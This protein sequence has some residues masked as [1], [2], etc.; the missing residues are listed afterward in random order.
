MTLTPLSIAQTLIRWNRQDY[1]RRFWKIV[2]ER[3]PHGRYSCTFPSK[4]EYERVK[5][6]TFPYDREK[7]RLTKN[8]IARDAKLKKF[9]SWAYRRAKR[10]R[11]T[12][13]L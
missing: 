5:Q 7:T 3:R 12:G 1:L 6:A 11:M 9:R 2:E 13:K 4:E 8:W 10:L